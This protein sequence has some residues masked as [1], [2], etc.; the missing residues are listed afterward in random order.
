L[1]SPPSTS[2]PSTSPPST[3]PPSTTLV[4]TLLQGLD[5]DLDDEDKEELQTLRRM[6]THRR[7]INRYFTADEDSEVEDPN[8]TSTDSENNIDSD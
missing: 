2:P 8:D 1:T 7:K 3:S 4:E 6:V 5:E